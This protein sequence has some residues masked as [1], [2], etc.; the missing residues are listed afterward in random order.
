MLSDNDAD[1]CE[2]KILHKECTSVV[3][4]LKRNKSPGI[5][6]LPGE[7]YQCFWDDIKHLVVDSYNEL[8]KMMNLVKLK[9][10]HNQFNFQKGR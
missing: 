10:D 7:F 3:Q 5:D 8:L 1:L 4:N 6:G 2:G 9:T